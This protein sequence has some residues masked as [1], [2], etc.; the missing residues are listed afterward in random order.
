M[1]LSD[2][3]LLILLKIKTNTVV[4]KTLPLLC[5]KTYKSRAIGSVQY[6]T[7]KHYTFII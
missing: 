5:L 7:F 2:L 4:T 3:D 6:F 1:A